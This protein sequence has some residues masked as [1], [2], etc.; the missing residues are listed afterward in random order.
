[1]EAT[2]TKI[3]M[4][5]RTTTAEVGIPNTLLPAVKHPRSRMVFWATIM[6]LNLIFAQGDV[7]TIKLVIVSWKVFET[8]LYNK[9]KIIVRLTYE[10][11]S[12]R[13]VSLTLFITPIS[14]E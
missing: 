2:T 3:P 10:Q 9:M 14:G 8:R 1:M 7:I 4:V 6:N 5:L 11:E 13:Q 12:S